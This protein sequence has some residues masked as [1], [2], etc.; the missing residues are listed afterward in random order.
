M[1][2]ALQSSGGLFN[3]LLGS[4]EKSAGAETGFTPLIESSQPLSSRHGTRQRELRHVGPASQRNHAALP[5]QRAALRSSSN[6]ELEWTRSN[7][8]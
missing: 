7:L 8:G 3:W 5:R 4:Q 2:T 6:Q 1:T